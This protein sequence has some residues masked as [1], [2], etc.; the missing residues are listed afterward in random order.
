MTTIKPGIYRHYKGNLYEVIGTAQHSETEEKMVVYRALY[1][2]FGLWV[3][4]AGMFAETI[5]D[6]GQELSRFTCVKSF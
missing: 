5:T 6:N 3:R 1:G 4:P 2:D